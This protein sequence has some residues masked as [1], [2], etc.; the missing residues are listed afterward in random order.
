VC[1]WLNTPALRFGVTLRYSQSPLPF[2]FNPEVILSFAWN[3]FQ[4]FFKDPAQ[5][6]SLKSGSFEV[7]APSAYWFKKGFWFQDLPHPEKV[8]FY[9]LITVL[10]FCP[11]S[12]LT[13]LFHTATLMGFPL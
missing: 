4:S 13:V 9:G 8:R 2:Q 5:K 11:C 6:L 1:Y 3:P 12:N 7:F 10:A